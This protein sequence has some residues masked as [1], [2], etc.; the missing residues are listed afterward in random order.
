MYGAED[1]A[2]GGGGGYGVDVGSYNGG[3]AAEG[4]SYGGGGGG[5]RCRKVASEKCDKIPKRIPRQ[6]CHKIPKPSCHSKPKQ[7]SS[8][9]FNWKPNSPFKN[10]SIYKLRVNLK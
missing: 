3:Y 1:N 4:R 2:Y 10:K 6:K 5:Y 9:F 7:V 8:G